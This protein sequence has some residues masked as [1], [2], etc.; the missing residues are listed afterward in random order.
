MVIKRT[1]GMCQGSCRVKVFTEDDRIVRVE[2]DTDSP[3][4]RVCARGALTPELL[5]SKDRLTYPLIRDGKRGEGKFRRVGWEE[6]LSF[7]AK[8]LRET[9]ERHGARALASYQGRGVLGMPVARILSGKEEDCLMKRLG[10]PNDFNAGS[11]CNMASSTVTPVTTL[12]MTT[13]QMAPDIKNSEYIFIWGKNPMTDCGPREEYKAICEAKKSGSKIV[14][15]DP[16]KDGMGT[17]ADLWIPVVPGADGALALAML[18]IIVEEGRY[19]RDFVRDFTRG[20]DELRDYLQT[21]T[22]EQLSAWCGVSVGQIRE[23]TGIFCS[24]EKISLVAY[25]GLEYQLSAIQNGR[26]IYTLW[27]LTGKLDVPG[28]MLFNC[29]HV[30]VY[31]LY[32]LPEENKPI[33]VDEFPMFYKFM[34]GGQFC[35]FPDAVLQDDP[36]P[37]RALLLAGGS[38]VLTFPDSSRWREAYERLECRIVLDRYMTEDARYADV[39]FPS[40]TMFETWKLSRGKSGEMELEAP[41]AFA[42]GEC[43]DDVLILAELA[44]RLG[45]GADYPGN[46]EELKKWLCGAIPPYAGDW[47]S[48]GLKKERS[49]RKYATGEL[50]EDGR[51]GFPTPSGKFEICSVYLEENGFTPYPA[52]KDMRSIP[53]MNLPEFPF[54][55]TTGARSMHRMGVFGANLPGI[56]K[57]EPYPYV[58]LSPADAKELGIVDGDWAR[59]STPFGSGSFRVRLSGMARHC[60][61]IPHGGGSAYMPE[62]WKYGNVNEL[63]SLSYNDPV[64]GFVTI[65]SVPCRVEKERQKKL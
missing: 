8:L 17:L 35:R 30:P 62:A 44:K 26:A 36:Y 47:Q 41:V 32:E 65:K 1:C 38:P 46:E 56:A 24:T 53:E 28:G 10:S 51:A 4:G 5:Y 52:Y 13:R 63:T 60:I 18:K 9:K 64:T 61:H 23:L 27:A 42:P 37:V 39:V 11:I 43:R 45:V 16:R 49:Y 15:I 54:T 6:A 48:R 33:G 12:G 7:A 29:K 2:A 31:S 40:S 50:R 25:T 3:Q 59:V 20:F 34:E 58:D 19:D 22:F 57:L 55:M 21:L 14:V